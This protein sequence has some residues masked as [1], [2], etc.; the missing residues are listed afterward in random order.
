M[1]EY[2]WTFPKFET[3]ADNNVKTIHWRYDA[4]E[5]VPDEFQGDTVYTAP[6]YGSCG[7]AENM[8]FDTM[9]KEQCVSC[10]LENLD[11]T[12]ADMQLNLSAQ[13]ANQKAQ[14]Q[15]AKV[16]EW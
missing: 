15:T 14:E 5:V 6:L 13:I 8:N 9:T 16:K 7:G 11:Q 4:S 2:K 10:V 12:E 3:D 1:I